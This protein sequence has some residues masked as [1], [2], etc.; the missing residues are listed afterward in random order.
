MKMSETLGNIEKKLNER[1]FTI[2]KVVFV[3]G[4]HNAG[5]VLVK[6]DTEHEPFVTWAFNGDGM[7]YSGH[8]FDDGVEA[9]DDFNK[10]TG[11]FTNLVV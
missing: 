7:F 6:R 4:N 1:G 5:N 2:L 11:V 9:N 8:Y 10:R 3:H